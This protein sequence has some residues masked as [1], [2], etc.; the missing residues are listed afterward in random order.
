MDTVNVIDLKS[1]LEWLVAGGAPIVVMYAI[2]LLAENWE[3]WHTL[4]KLV[5]FLVPMILSALLAVGAQVLTGY[6]DVIVE[7]IAPWWKV[8]V[9]AIM[10][11]IGSQKAYM[12]TK[13]SGYGTHNSV[14]TYEVIEEEN[15]V[16]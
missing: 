12:S 13:L 16:L 15:D 7:Q 11:Y 2:S 14:F 9:V 4:P 1:V 10:A 6:A 3:K 8:V 5:K